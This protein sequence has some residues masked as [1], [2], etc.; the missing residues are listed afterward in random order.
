MNENNTYQH[1]D[2]TKAL[3]SGGR[4]FDEIDELT[5]EQTFR[6]ITKWDEEIA[7]QNL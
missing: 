1:P 5:W 2:I 6:K 7:I 3:A 4:Y